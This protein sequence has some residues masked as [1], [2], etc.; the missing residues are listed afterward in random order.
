MGLL[1]M[2]AVAIYGVATRYLGTL[3]TSAGWGLYQIFMIAA[4]NVSGLVL[5]E[6]A[7]AGGRAISVLLLGLVLLALATVLMSAANR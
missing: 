7:K 4:A 6:W 1:W 3:G 5:G 2:S